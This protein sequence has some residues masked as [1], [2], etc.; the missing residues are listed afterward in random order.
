VADAAQKGHERAQLAL[1]IFAD[2]IR[3]VIGSLAVTLGRLDGLVFAG[4]IGEHSA[5]LRALVC[6][7]LECLGLQ[8]DSSR[9]AACRPDS[10]I[11]A[12]ASIK[13]IWVIATREDEMIA[14]EVLRLTGPTADE[15][16]A[17]GPVEKE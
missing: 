3:G 8:L 6:D 14:R 15:L 7:G 1:D 16:M 11:G 5:F 12:Y 10:E 4:G 2:R 17:V 9:N 13:R